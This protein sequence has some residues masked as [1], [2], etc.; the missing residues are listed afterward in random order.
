MN[1]PINETLM[2]IECPINGESNVPF[3]SN[4]NQHINVS[5]MRKRMGH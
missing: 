2:N 4:I 5:L 3:M 1:D